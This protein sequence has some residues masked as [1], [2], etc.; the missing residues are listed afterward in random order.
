MEFRVRR[1]GSGLVACVLCLGFWQ[2]GQG[3]YIPAKAWFAQELMLRAWQRN[4]IEEPWPWEDAWPIAKLTANKGR[5]DL[6]VLAGSSGNT[7]AFGPGHLDASVMPGRVGNSV[8]AGHRDTHFQFLQNL[9]I[10]ERIEVE[11]VNGLATEFDVIDLDIVD[12]RRSSLTLDA[13]CPMLTLITGFP[14][15]PDEPAGRMNY[16]VTARKSGER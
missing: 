12:G 4:G 15:D 9:A 3:A 2:L 13:D 8:I 11:L 14:F 6:I 5:I 16:V 10:G 7:L 1:V